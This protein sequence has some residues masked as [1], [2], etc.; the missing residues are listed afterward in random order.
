MVAHTMTTLLHCM[1]NIIKAIGIETQ[2]SENK[3]H[4]SVPR[5]WAQCVSLHCKQ[6]ALSFLPEQQSTEQNTEQKNVL[7][8]QPLPA[9]VHT[10][11]GKAGRN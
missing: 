11:S 8:R 9:N 4:Y 7:S 6:L 10:V 2:P 5:I 1:I 3:V